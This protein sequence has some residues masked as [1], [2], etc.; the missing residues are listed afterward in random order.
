[1]DDKI[2]SENKSAETSKFFDDLMDMAE[3]VLYAVFIVLLLFTYVLRIATVEGS[4]M[5]PTLQN[6]DRLIVSDIFFTPKQKDI[7]IIKSEKAHLFADESETEVIESDG[8][9]KRIVKRVIATEGQTVDIDFELGDVY[10]DGE[11]IYE[12]YI[13]DLTT[14]DEGAFDY[15]I[16]IP[17]GYLF[18]MGDNRMWSKD[19]RHP[20]VGL[21]KNEDVSGHVIL[22]IAPF[23]KFGFIY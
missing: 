9:N 3:S 16:T 14:R 8:L 11:K 17:E 23:E 13:A 18:V 7:I 6:D 5:E 15:P 2:N 21:I 22:R 4:S 1:M 10:V 20:E 12:S 19:S